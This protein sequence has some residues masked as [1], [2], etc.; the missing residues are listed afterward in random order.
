MVPLKLVF[1]FSRFRP[2]PNLNRF[3]ADLSRGSNSLNSDTGQPRDHNIVFVIP[4]KQTNNASILPSKKVVMFR[5]LP[6]SGMLEF[7]RFITAHHWLKVIEENIVNAIAEAFHRT[8]RSKFKE[9]F[10]EKIVT[11]SPLDMNSF[12]KKINRQMKRENW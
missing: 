11:I 7:G 10:P 1:N 5:P 8:I 4:T 3:L 2:A 6:E 12:L 9:I